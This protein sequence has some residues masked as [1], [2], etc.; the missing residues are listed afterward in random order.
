MV[1]KMI[2][3]GSQSV[4]AQGL[5]RMEGTIREVMLGATTRE[6]TPRGGTPRMGTPR[7]G[8]NREGTTRAGIIRMEPLLTVTIM[9]VML[10]T[11]MMDPTP[12]GKIEAPGRTGRPTGTKIPIQMAA[13]LGAKTGAVPPQSSLLMTKDPLSPLMDRSP[14]TATA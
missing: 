4:R 10:T 7:V 13:L 14:P 2:V 6:G 12:M 3:L 1:L 8:T 9:L 5:I 11:K